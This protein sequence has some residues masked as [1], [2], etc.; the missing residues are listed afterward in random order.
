[1]MVHIVSFQYLLKLNQLNAL[2][3]N[4]RLYSLLISQA[5]KRLTTTA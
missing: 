3:E 4:I 2:L 5:E 1:M